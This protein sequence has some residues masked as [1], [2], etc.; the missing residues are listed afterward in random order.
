MSKTKLV[1]VQ[2]EPRE[3]FDERFKKM[4]RFTFTEW[5]KTA[6]CHTDSEMIEYED[7]KIFAGMTAYDS[8]FKVYS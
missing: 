6:D 3:Q 4:F 7:G 1:L 5:I 8:G 2:S